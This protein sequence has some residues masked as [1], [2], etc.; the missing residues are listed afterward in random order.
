MIQ[1]NNQQQDKQSTP[2]KEKPNGWEWHGNTGGAGHG[3]CD[4]YLD[5]H[6]SK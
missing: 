2:V 1:Q 3:R 5:Q 6:R 4:K